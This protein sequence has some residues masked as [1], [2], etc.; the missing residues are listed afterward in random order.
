M[1]SKKI[2]DAKNQYQILDSDINILLGVGGSGPTKRVSAE[3]FIEF[4]NFCSKKFKCKFFL[5]AGSNN[6][7]QEIINKKEKTNE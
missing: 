1:N 7:E 3:K 4:M 2:E 5:A 6:I